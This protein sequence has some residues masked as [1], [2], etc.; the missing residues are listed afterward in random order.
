MGGERKSS[1]FGPCEERAEKESRGAPPRRSRSNL[2]KSR[3]CSKRAPG[4]AKSGEPGARLLAS[5]AVCENHGIHPNGAVLSFIMQNNFFNLYKKKGE[6]CPT[7]F[8]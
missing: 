8:P 5:P 4:P 3:A 7:D 6:P 1:V 2:H